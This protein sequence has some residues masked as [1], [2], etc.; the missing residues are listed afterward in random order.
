[1]Y[2]DSH[3]GNTELPYEPAILFLVIYSRE[4]KIYTT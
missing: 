2:N 1:M 4:M 3:F